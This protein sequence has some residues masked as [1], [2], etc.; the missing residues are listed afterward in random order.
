MSKTAK[1]EMFRN[2]RGLL[3]SSI[4]KEMHSIYLKVTNDPLLVGMMKVG[5]ISEDELC[6]LAMDVFMNAADAV[7]EPDYE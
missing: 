7:T 3:V 1:T 6:D 2:I 4:E 5:A